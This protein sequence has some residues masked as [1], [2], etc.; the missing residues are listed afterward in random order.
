MFHSMYSTMNFR[1]G[2]IFLRVLKNIHWRSLLST[3]LG[4]LRTL[5]VWRFVSR[6]FGWSINL[7]FHL[8]IHPSI[9]KS[10]FNWTIQSMTLSHYEPMQ[11]EILVIKNLAKSASRYVKDPILIAS[12]SYN[13][14]S[15]CILSVS[16]L[17]AALSSREVF[18]LFL[19]LA[20]S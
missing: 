16:G 17:F 11:I 9:S 3:E 13:I 4:R 14:C 20:N 1:Y 15:W 10:I 12:S 6:S 5:F 8:Y 18:L 7:S 19:A 2:H